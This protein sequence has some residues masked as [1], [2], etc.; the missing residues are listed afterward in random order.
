MVNLN[1]FM[2]MRTLDSQVNSNH[3]QKYSQRIEGF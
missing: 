3:D 1:M 2:I